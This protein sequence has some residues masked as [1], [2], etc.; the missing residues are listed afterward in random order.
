[1]ACPEL[2]EG[3]VGESGLRVLAGDRPLPEASGGTGEPG[4]RS[5]VGRFADLAAAVAAGGAVSPAPF[6]AGFGE[7]V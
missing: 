4:E 5:A 7:Y 1:M 3:N 6:L 2:V